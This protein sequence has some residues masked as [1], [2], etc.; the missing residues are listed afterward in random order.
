MYHILG[1]TKLRVYRL[2]MSLHAAVN[3]HCGKYIYQPALIK[4]VRRG[5]HQQHMHINKQLTK[6]TN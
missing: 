3:L 2:R 6:L 4:W 5:K 1:R